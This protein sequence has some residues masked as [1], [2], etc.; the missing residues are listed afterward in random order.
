MQSIQLTS[1]QGET[2]AREAAALLVPSD[3]LQVSHRLL[4]VRR[5][6]DVGHD[7]WSVFNVVQEN[8]MLGKSVAYTLASVDE[9]GRETKRTMTTRPIKPNTGKDAVFNQN[10]FDIALKIAA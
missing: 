1:E 7:L 3:A 10:L 5:S 6:E 9:L 2:L 8:A 4:R